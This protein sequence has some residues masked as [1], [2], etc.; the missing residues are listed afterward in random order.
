ML[1]NG[2]PLR[3]VRILDMATVL[4]APFSAT[5]C[6]DMG[7]EVVKLEL[8]QGN[9]ALRGLAPVHEGHALFWK[10]ANR[11]KQ[12][13]SLDV[14]QPEGRELF[15][16]L[17]EG[18]D[19]LVE[20]FRTG[21]LDG[22]GLD[23]ATLHA[24]NP[25]LIVLRLTGFGQT[26]PYARKPG[27]ARIFEAMSGFAHLTG[28]AGGPPQHMN[29]PLG[30]A[31]AGLF[32]AFAIATALAERN[33]G[34][35]EA[36]RGV[37]IDLS[38]TEAM[39]RLL[40]PLA[41]EYQFSGRARERAG[42]RA[43]YTAPSNVYRT[44]DGAWITLVGSSDPIFVRL[45]GAMEQSALAADPRFATNVQ[46]TTNHVEIDRIVAAWCASLPLAALSERL[47]R[48]EV[49]YSKVYSI[50]DVIED[51]HFRERGALL[52]LQ[53]PELGAV[54][55]PAVVPR[56]VGRTPGVPAVG[57]RT[58]QDNEAV[59]AALGVQPEELEHLRSRR[60]I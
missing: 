11:G 56:F 2:Y 48:H 34:P 55:A 54:A 8:P 45:C 4:A 5:L 20:N 57:P 22:W 59:Y 18:F 17:I 47:D 25:R 21:T 27:F 1:Q 40:D 51:P 43:S 49:P 28:E 24:R 23:L 6:G 12:G 14:R 33:A 50:A 13:I 29:Y 35:R 44:E 41:A 46:R 52:E 3:G 36:Q 31:I 30:D 15:L 42:S 53:D 7:A 10:T 37:E 58:G 38:A 32:G 26:G 60:V 39:L 16:R 9:D 19:V